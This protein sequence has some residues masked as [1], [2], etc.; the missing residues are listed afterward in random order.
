M[1]AKDQESYRL[2]VTKQEAAQLARKHRA[3]QEQ[4]MLEQRPAD[5]AQHGQ[6]AE[7][8]EQRASAKQTQQ[9]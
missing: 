9:Q 8:W 7:Y 4:L 2:T 1:A 3:L 6:I 5:A